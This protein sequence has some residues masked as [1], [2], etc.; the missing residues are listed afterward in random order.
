LGCYASS[1][2]IDKNSS[3][4]KNGKSHKKNTD[5]K[6]GDI[7][8]TYKELLFKM[9]DKKMLTL[10]ADK[11]G[12]GLFWAGMDNMEALEK[13][14][15]LGDLFDAEDF[16]HKYPKEEVDSM[17]ETLAESEWE[18]L[19]DRDLKAIL[20]DGCIGWDNMSDRDVI[21][22]YEP[23]YYPDGKSDWSASKDSFEDVYGESDNYKESTIR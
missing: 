8:M 10:S 14:F 18:G 7:K 22:I 16:T 17:R 21:D 6:I 23:I 3:R 5:I 15:D 9:A 11:D 2:G 13:P 4:K 1:E 12:R 20:R 19:K